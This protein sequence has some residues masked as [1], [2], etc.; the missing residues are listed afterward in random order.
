[1]APVLPVVVLNAE[2]AEN[3]RYAEET[4]VPLAHAL[5]A[6]GLKTIEITLRSPVALASIRAVTEQVP[7]AVVGAGTVL[8]PAMVDQA[9]AAGSRFLVTPGSTTPLLDAC[10]DTGLPC[11]PGAATASEALALWER[12][13]R[14][15]KFFPAEA[16]GGVAYL[17]A[18]AGP[19][20][21]ARFCPTGGI[22]AA[23]ARDY[24]ALPNV[25]SVGGTWMVPPEALAARDWS[26]VT[27]LA[28]AAAALSTN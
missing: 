21:E 12:G 13:Y 10:Q 28:A 19:L 2:T 9:V 17:R 3:T 8:S 1:M 25:A 5:V 18:L 15:I 26:R 11:L 27:E 16:A 22:T 24:L 7:E 4:A 20:P 23:N 14:E 6:G